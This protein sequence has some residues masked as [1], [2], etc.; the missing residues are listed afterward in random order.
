MIRRPPRSTLFPYTTLFRSQ[1]VRAESERAAMLEREHA[2]HR[3]V[4]ERQALLDLVI[5]QSG[6]AVVVT[7]AQGVIQLFNAEAERQHG[8]SRQ[9]VSAPEWASTFGLLCLRSEER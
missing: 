4:E 3:A 9:Q 5:E 7:D 6:D 2:A 8:V 1:R